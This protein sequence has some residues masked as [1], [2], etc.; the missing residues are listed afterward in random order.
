MCD[1]SPEALRWFDRIAS[2]THKTTDRRHLLED[3]T[4]DVL[5]L[6]VPHHLHEELYLD[7]IAAGK[8]F[9]GEKPFGIDLAAAERIVAAVEDAGVFVR[10]SSEMPFFPGAQLAYETIAAGALGQVIEVQHDF[11]H[12][13]DL[14]RAKPINWKRQARYCGAIGVMG[15]LGMHVAHLPLRLGLAPGHRLRRSCSDLVTERPDPQTGE[16]VPCDTIDNATLHVRRRLPADP[17]H[18]ADRARADEHLAHRGA[19]HGRRRELLDR[20]AR[21]PCTA[22]RCATGARCGSASRSAA[23]RPSPP[24]PERSSSSASPT[25]SCR[26]G[27][28]TWPSARA[29]WATRFGCATPRE[30][31]D[32]HRVFDAALR[33]G[34]THRA[35]PV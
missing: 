22:S 1:T 9:L 18:P 27:P 15:D 21:R 11:L 7:A 19:R 31:L 32:A 34:Q 24:S 23:S 35:E 20:P 10:C 17:A 16:P 3:D 6:A 12:S 5:Y 33:S 25:R 8:D 13:S 2:V 4:I 26:C 30:A 28:P 29:R 14:D